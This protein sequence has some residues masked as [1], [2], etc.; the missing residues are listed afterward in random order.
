MCADCKRF[1][2]RKNEKATLCKI[3]S[4][5]S[6][7]RSILML[8]Q[9]DVDLESVEK[10]G[11][12]NGIYFVLGGSVPILEK[13]PEKRIRVKELKIFI[14]KKIKE[15]TNNIVSIQE[16]IFHQGFNQIDYIINLLKKDPDSRRIM[17][18]AWKADEI[19]EM[20]LP[21]CH[22]GFQI[23]TR[24]MKSSERY[25]EYIQWCDERNLPITPIVDFPERKIS[26]LLNIRSNDVG[27]GNPFNVAEY[28]LLLH[29]I[30]QVVNMIPEKLII[31]L[32]DAHIYNNHI[33]ALKEVISRESFDLPKLKLNE[34]IKNI[35]DFR[36]EDI[37]IENYQSHP[38]I[39]MEVA[40]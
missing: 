30:A 5:S 21:P 11:G 22:Y 27:L 6:R 7:D 23:Y 15:G 38:N 33:D 3:C 10:N 39:K 17:V 24:K 13:E 2:E 4:D 20:L 1:F 26:L 32:G 34:N 36:Y 29:M 12:F 25:E 16:T 19:D 8:V 9:R 31:T 14:E 37:I 18:N 40:V 35:Y 28:A